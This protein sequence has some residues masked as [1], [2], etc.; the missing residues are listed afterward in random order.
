MLICKH[1][2]AMLDLYIFKK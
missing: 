1:S 2:G